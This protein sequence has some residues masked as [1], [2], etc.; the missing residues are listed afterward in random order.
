[1]RCP[2][3][4][5][6]NPADAVFCQEC[7]ARL[8]RAC[9]GCGTANR[10]DAK[11]CKTCG[12]PVALGPPAATGAKVPH[13]LSYPPRHL[14]EKIL[15]SKRGLA[16]ERKLV[17]VL[18]ADVEKSMELAERL[19]PE[20]WSQIMQRFFRILCDSLERFEGF[21]DKFTGHGGM[22]QGHNASPWLRAVRGCTIRSVTSM[23]LRSVLRSVGAWVAMAL[24]VLAFEDG[25]HSVHHLPDHD[26][27]S[28]CALAAISAQ[29]PA[30]TVD[31]VQ[32]GPPVLVAT[33]A[34]VLADPVVPDVDAP[35]ADRGRA[36]PVL[37]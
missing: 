35:R 6:E 20:V 8:E 3:C 28:P 18:F 9:P 27:A 1:M 22:A 31:S 21:V 15:T 19:D 26:Q 13:P 37:S 32:I 2:R 34:V 11:F 12:Q 30:T 14:A 24:L 7:G 36:P 33:A 16:G 17:T 25:V 10:L 23:F 29:V 5:R 4:Q